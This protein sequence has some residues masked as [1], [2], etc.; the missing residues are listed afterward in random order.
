MI[1]EPWAPSD[2]WPGQPAGSLRQKQQESAGAIKHWRPVPLII[3]QYC[4]PPST[5]GQSEVRVHWSAA[6]WQ[7]RR[8]AQLPGASAS[9]LPAAHSLPGAQSASVV[10]VDAMQVPTGSPQW[11]AKPEPQ[12]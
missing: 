6:V 2:V 7:A 8:C 10:Q 9:P 11:Q 1:S 5:R 12:S 4:G 3:A